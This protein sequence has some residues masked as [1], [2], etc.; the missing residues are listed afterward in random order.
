MHSWVRHQHSP[1][2]YHRKYQQHLKH[3]FF[4]RTN[5]ATPLQLLHSFS[6]TTIKKRRRKG[7]ARICIEKCIATVRVDTRALSK[8]TRDGGDANTLPEVS[9]TN[10]YADKEHRW[11]RYTALNNETHGGGGTCLLHR[12]SWQLY[13]AL[14]RRI[15]L[16]STAGMQPRPSALWTITPTEYRNLL[17]GVARFS[18]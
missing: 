17:Q 8:Q 15:H 13:L 6:S 14:I 9:G 11:T 2:T 10:G 1:T 18:M 5:H 4:T 12:S 16:P 7:A 3:S